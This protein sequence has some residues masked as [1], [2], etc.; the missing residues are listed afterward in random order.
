VYLDREAITTSSDTTKK[1]ALKNWDRASTEMVSKKNRAG[2]RVRL[3]ATMARAAT[4]PAALN[5]PII[6]PLFFIN[7]PSNMIKIARTVR[8]ASPQSGA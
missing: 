7:D 3:L 8:S 5:I 4:R 6:L 2:L 1:T